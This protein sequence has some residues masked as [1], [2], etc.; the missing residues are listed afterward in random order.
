MRLFV[1]LLTAFLSAPLLAATDINSSIEKDVAEVC[2]KFD[3]QKAYD[4]NGRSEE[5]RVGK[6]CR[7]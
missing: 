3:S 1:L 7:L 4:E 5:R 6:E 2:H